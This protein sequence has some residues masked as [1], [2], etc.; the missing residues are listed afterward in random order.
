MV[1]KELAIAA[2]AVNNEASTEHS[3]QYKK[4]AVLNCT[5]EIQHIKN[6]LQDRIMISKVYIS[7]TD[8]CMPQG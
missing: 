6:T 3:I 1:S 5:I 4:K 8:T 2:P 7:V